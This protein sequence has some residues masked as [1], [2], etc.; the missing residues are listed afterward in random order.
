[1]SSPTLPTPDSLL[2][3]AKDNWMLIAGAVLGLAVLGG[4]YGYFKDRQG[5]AALARNP[6]PAH[7]RL[8]SLAEGERGRLRLESPSTRLEERIERQGRLPALDF[9]DGQAR[10]AVRNPSHASERAR[11]KRAARVRG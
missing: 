6:S 7:K 9:R 8:R 11:A 1:M 10:E 3:K 2:Q 4:A 5:G